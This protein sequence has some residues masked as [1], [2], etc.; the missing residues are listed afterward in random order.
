MKTK[1]CLREKKEAFS[2]K[3]KCPQR[4]KLKITRQFVIDLVKISNAPNNCLYNTV[5][6]FTYFDH[7]ND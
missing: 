5:P 7:D 4:R 1:L 3:K 6:N 2:L